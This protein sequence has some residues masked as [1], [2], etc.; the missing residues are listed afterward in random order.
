MLW[1]TRSPWPCNKRPKGTREVVEQLVNRS[2]VYYVRDGKVGLAAWLLRVDLD[3]VDDVT[4]DNFFDTPEHA[5]AILDNLEEICADNVEDVALAHLSISGPAS[6]PS[7][8]FWH[9]GG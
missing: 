2:D 1:P 4:W 8:C 6:R 3:D 7:S 9:A 5:E